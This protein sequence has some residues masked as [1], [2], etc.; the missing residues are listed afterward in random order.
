MLSKTFRKLGMVLTVVMA[1]ST[2]NKADVLAS[3]KMKYGVAI[4]DGKKL[5]KINILIT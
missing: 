4:K 5:Q 1:I 2:I 3:E